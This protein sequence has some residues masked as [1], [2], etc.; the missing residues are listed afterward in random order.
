MN[1]EQKL[2]A[3]K[4]TNALKDI[5][6]EANKSFTPQ[7]G[8]T[9]K[10]ILEDGLLIPSIDK[11][12]IIVDGKVGT[13]DVIPG[14]DNI[15][16]IIKPDIFYDFSLYVE[17]SCPKGSWDNQMTFKDR[18]GDTYHLRIFSSQKKLHRVRYHSP[19]GAI[20]K[21]TWNIR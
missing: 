19:D 12:P 20:E 21:I 18:S 10:G 2:E 3:I 13:E 7:G 17:G 8:K 16:L 11:K 5:L 15:W 9:I 1:T 4:D 14:I 6:K